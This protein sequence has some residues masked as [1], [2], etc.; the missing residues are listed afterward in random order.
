MKVYKELFFNNNSYNVCINTND[1][2]GDGC[3]REIFTNNEYLLHNFVNL[4]SHIID[5]GA[6]CGMATIILAKQNPES[7][8]YA[9]EPHYPTFLLL[10]E[11]VEL[12]KLTNVH[13][14]NMAVSDSSNKKL[15]L[16]NHPDF[17]GG[18][19]T[20]SNSEVFANHFR[21]PFETVEVD[22]ISLDEIIEKYNIDN[23]HLL[24]IDCEGAEYEILY[25]SQFFKNKMIKNIVGEFHNLRYNI[26]P[27]KNNYKL[28][29]YCNQYVDGIKKITMLT[30]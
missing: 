21:R 5:I 14:F 15:T 7:K 28:L 17:S 20:C 4:K 16:Y 24:K 30:I 10:Q 8:I 18:N 25:N 2:S 3:I 12:N 1:G 22:C 9:F 6:N 19:T 29:E 13:L 23:V 26:T 11:N 27:E